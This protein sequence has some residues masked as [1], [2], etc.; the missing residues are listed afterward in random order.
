[1]TVLLW[2]ILYPFS[3]CI[4]HQLS[5]LLCFAA[6]ILIDFYFFIIMSVGI[7]SS[8]IIQHQSLSV[9]L[10]VSGSRVGGFSITMCQHSC[11]ESCS[12]GRWYSAPYGVKHQEHNNAAYDQQVSEHTSFLVS[13]LVLH[14]SDLLFLFR[15]KIKLIFSIIIPAIKMFSFSSTWI[16]LQCCLFSGLKAL[17][18]RCLGTS[19]WHTVYTKVRHFPS[20]CPVTNPVFMFCAFQHSDI[21]N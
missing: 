1:M 5:T 12:P 18:T 14:I 7:L 11:L 21:R 6:L 20:Y 15:L 4:T 13:F 8:S 19:S 2:K 9:L 16:L 3:E 10:V 17:S